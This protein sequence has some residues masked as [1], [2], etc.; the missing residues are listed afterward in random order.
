MSATIDVVCYV[1]VVNSKTDEKEIRKTNESW[2]M[3]KMGKLVCMISSGANA[4]L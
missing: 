2:L 4:L 3:V 1:L